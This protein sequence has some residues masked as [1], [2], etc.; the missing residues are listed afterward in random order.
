MSE[1]S[2]WGFL[3]VL[4]VGF[5]VSGVF[6]MWDF[7]G[8]VLSVDFLSAGILSWIPK[9]HQIQEL[10]CAKNICSQINVCFFMLKIRLNS[11]KVNT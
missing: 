2:N 10:K 1:F 9:E 8:G 7:V 5:F 6:V 11:L 4:S 3:S